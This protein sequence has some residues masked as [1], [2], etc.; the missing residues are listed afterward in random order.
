MKKVVP[1]YYDDSNMDTLDQEMKD[2]VAGLK[3]NWPLEWMKNKSEIA[4]LKR[5][6]TRKKKCRRHELFMD[7][8][9]RSMRSCLP[10]L[11]KTSN[12]S[13]M[14]IF[15]KKRESLDRDI[16]IFI[17]QNIFIKTMESKDIDPRLTKLINQSQV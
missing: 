3:D 1:A 11:I 16:R 13:F 15:G 9:Q 10:E 17:R 4:K 5:I 8:K 14:N 2:L 12:S 6:M 7:R